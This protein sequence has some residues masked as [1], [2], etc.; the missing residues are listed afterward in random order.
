MLEP[1]AGQAA[2]RVRSMPLG[3]ASPS[4]LKGLLLALWKAESRLAAPGL[5]SS[6]DVSM[7]L[8]FLNRAKGALTGA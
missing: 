7:V 5:A 2:L 4:D 8:C 1:D 3:V 6:R